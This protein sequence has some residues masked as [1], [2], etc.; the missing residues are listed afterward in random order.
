MIFLQDVQQ[1][2]L[3]EAEYFGLPI[4]LLNGLFDSRIESVMKNLDDPSFFDFGDIG[5]SPVTN[6]WGF[7]RGRPV[8]RY[9]IESFLQRYSEHIKGHVV[10]VGDRGYTH[11][12]GNGRVNTTDVWDVN[13]E[14]NMATIVADL[15]CAS[16]VP[17][18]TFDCF[19][20]TQVLVLIQNVEE[21]VRELYRVIKPGGVALITV[22]GISQISSVDEEATSWSWSFYPKTLKRILTD[23][24]F[25]QESLV[26][27]GMGNLK[28]TVAFLAQ[29]AQSDLKPQ[30][31]EFNDNRYPLVV[32]ARAVKPDL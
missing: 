2:I 23:A 3:N 21:A 22:P 10:E 30:D 8:D 25:E 9:Y 14:N 4:F 32:V 19:I 15:S 12:F 24:G 6:D 17:S 1:Y 18:N 28:T 27:E 7:S 13:S 26:V 31:Y 16:H 20:L 11:R 5:L 29:L